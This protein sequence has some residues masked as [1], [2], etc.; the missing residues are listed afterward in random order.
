MTRGRSA[1][2]A[3]TQAELGGRTPDIVTLTRRR[4]AALDERSPAEVS[5]AR[6]KSAS[7]SAG[8][9]FRN[10]PIDAPSR[11]RCATSRPRWSF[12]RPTRLLTNS[13]LGAK[14]QLGLGI[15]R[16]TVTGG[17]RAPAT[18]VGHDFE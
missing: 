14:I 13:E 2:G 9:S 18:V 15:A 1:G 12:A 4:T 3:P 17:P 5:A 7:S 8:T 11:I 6:Q 10:W 16:R